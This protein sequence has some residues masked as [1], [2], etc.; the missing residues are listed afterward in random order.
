MNTKRWTVCLLTKHKWV[1]AEYP[2]SEGARFIRC[3]RCGYEFQ[4]ERMGWPSAGV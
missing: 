4:N 1:T 2:G 3:S